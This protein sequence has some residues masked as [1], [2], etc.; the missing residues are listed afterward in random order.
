MSKNLQKNF[1]IEE[2]IKE[3]L[4]SLNE[5][6]IIASHGSYIEGCPL[7]VVYYDRENKGCVMLDEYKLSDIYDDNDEIL[8]EFVSNHPERFIRVPHEIASHDY[9]LMEDF[10]Y[11][12][13]NSKLI[14]ALLGR[15]P[16]ATFNDLVAELRLDKEWLDFRSNAYDE[17]F[18]KWA[19]EY[20]I[21]L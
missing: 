19:E 16:M 11:M 3:Q 13:K 14:Q 12:K 8:S 9:D 21:E 4:H 2:I 20:D 17:Q 10:A 5:G 1:N 18:K 15:K 7:F 6:I